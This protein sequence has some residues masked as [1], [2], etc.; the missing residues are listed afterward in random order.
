MIRREHRAEAGGDDVEGVVVEGQGFG[1][2]FGPL[3]VRARGACGAAAGGEVFGRQIGGHDRG[4]GE[5][6]ADGDVAGAGGDVEDA[7]AGRD[8]AGLDQHRAELP[9]RCRREGVIVAERPHGALC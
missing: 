6:R 8:A 2:G 9:H 7:L 1:V 5:R 3:E 4:A